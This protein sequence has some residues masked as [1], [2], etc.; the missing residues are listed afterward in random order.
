MYELMINTDKW[1]FVALSVIVVILLGMVFK[2]VFKPGPI[3]GPNSATG[4]ISN[5]SQ[6]KNIDFFNTK[7]ANIG[8]T[9]SIFIEKE[10]K[11]YYLID[12]G[13]NKVMIM[14]EDIYEPE[15]GDEK[16]AK[17][18]VGLGDIVVKD[19]VE[20]SPNAT[21]E[22]KH[23]AAQILEEEAMDIDAI[24]AMRK[25]AEDNNRAYMQGQ[26][27]LFTTMSEE[28]TEEEEDVDEE[29]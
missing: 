24:E 14:E 15:I 17:Q 22:D 13:N 12:M 27:S 20:V 23:Y 11:H 29:Q 28:N 18:V 10:N 19:Y 9:T 25:I 21:E 4:N 8:K 5:D 3:V 1:I 7:S 6:S 16:I 2:Y 26:K